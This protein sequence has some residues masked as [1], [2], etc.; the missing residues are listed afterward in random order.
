MHA[1]LQAAALAAA[2]GLVF[3][4][5]VDTRHPVIFGGPAA[6]ADA[7]FG[8]TV[9]LVAGTQPWVLVGAPRANSTL[10]VHP[11]VRE[12]GALFR[13][14]ALA[15]GPCQ[16]V[17]VDADGNEPA[18]DRSYTSLRDAGWLGGSLDVQNGAGGRLVVCAPR[19]RNQRYGGH[20][21]GNGACY[22][23]SN[24]AVDDSFERLVPLAAKD[25]QYTHLVGINAYLYSY[26]Q[27]GVSA[28]LAQDS[29]ALL[30]GAPGVFDWTG[31]V[32]RYSPAGDLLVPDPSA[33][34]DRMRRYDYFGYADRSYDVLS[35]RV[36]DQLGEYFGAAVLAVDVNADGLS[37]AL[38][39]APLASPAGGGGDEGRV[40]VYINDG[41]GRLGEPT[42]LEGGAVGGRLGTAL[43]PLGDLDRDG[44]EDVAVAAPYEDE[45]RG[46]V[47]VFR[48][49]PGRFAATASQ[50]IAARD[51]GDALRGFGVSVSRGVDIDGNSH[52]DLAVGAYGSGHV[53]LLRAS[54][55]IEF[56]SSL[57]SSPERL[58]MTRDRFQ[59]RACLAFGGEAVDSVTVDVAL[60]IESFHAQGVFSVDGSQQREANFTL[61]ISRDE[62][63]CRV[64]DVALLASKRIDYTKPMQINMRYAV[65]GSGA[66]EVRRT[67]V[68]TDTEKKRLVDYEFSTRRRRQIEFPQAPPRADSFC[69]LC[70]VP[71]VNLPNQR[72]TTL[73][74]PFSVGCGADATC[75]TDLRLSHRFLGLSGGAYVVGST[76]T[77][78][79]ELRAAGPEG[80]T[81]ICNVLPH[82]F[83]DNSEYRLPLVFDMKAVTGRTG[84]LTFN[85]SV[86]SAGEELTPADNVANISL[87]LVSQAD[88]EIRGRA[89][90]PSLVFENAPVED[91]EDG[92]A[93]FEFV[94][95]TYQV[96]KYLPT[97]VPAVNISFL[98][99]VDVLAA[100]GTVVN[101]ARVYP[102]A[103]FVDSQPLT[104]VV[105]DDAYLLSGRQP[106][107]VAALS[108][109]G[110]GRLLLTSSG[111]VRMLGDSLIP[112]ELN[113][114]PDEARVTTELLAAT[115]TP[116]EVPTW[117]VVV[118]VLGALLLLALITQG[119]HLAGFFRRTR[120]EQLEQQQEQQQEQE[121]KENFG[122]M[123]IVPG[124]PAAAVK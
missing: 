98:V 75:Q 85:A 105:E 53:V 8:Y 113:Q 54:P 95:H 28:H 48:G 102:P 70:P 31:T 61:E 83:F 118:A 72:V 78:E 112:A 22:V 1:L 29:G 101:I 76:G 90:E 47:Y 15:A 60:R 37:D 80:V 96:L 64:L 116:E 91:E 109:L 6:D 27:A 43:A 92:G 108:S 120:R 104:C 106:T 7:Y 114:R 59:V 100:D 25:K 77:L 11:E 12:P 45:G 21:L 86:E 14:P 88:L 44:Y 13:C 121:V 10:G 65:A 9:A 99:P 58:D 51:L 94:Q 62:P 4:F 41:G 40:Y 66:E 111:R 97:P 24:D 33:F 89:R 81:L 124:P 18:P 42:R 3:P 19:W 49:G 122:H 38:V 55:V 2:L 115:L 52:P 39:G 16:E 68:D 30:L 20:R 110:V 117:I 50:R 93:K 26:G 34:P 5:N 46:A 79:L 103:A 63:S 74:V 82:P 67:F 87:P 73:S 57:T 32:A 123:F 36:G 56:V 107:A 17:L 119:L 35:E 71:N 23:G 69:P 84:R